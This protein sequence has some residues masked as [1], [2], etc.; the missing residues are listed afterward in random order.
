ME[1]SFQFISH[2]PDGGNEVIAQFAPQHTNVHVQGSGVLWTVVFT[3]NIAQN[4]IPFENL[5]RI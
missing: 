3:P 2:S 5:S 4:L 1:S